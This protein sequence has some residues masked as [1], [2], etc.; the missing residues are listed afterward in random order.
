MIHCMVNRG[1]GYLDPPVFPLV[2]CVRSF[3][4]AV[5]EAEVDA[6]RPAREVVIGGR[7]DGWWFPCHVPG[8]K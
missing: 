1:K 3:V 8:P 2:V 4:R 5:Q 6:N 7:F